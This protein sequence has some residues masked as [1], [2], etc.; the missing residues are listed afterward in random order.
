M[1]AMKTAWRG[2]ST[3]LGQT[4]T[5]NKKEASLLQPLATNELVLCPLVPSLDSSGQFTGAKQSANFKESF[6]KKGDSVKE[7]EVRDKGET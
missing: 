5:K 2:D 1:S 6:S 3:D 7:V 4:K